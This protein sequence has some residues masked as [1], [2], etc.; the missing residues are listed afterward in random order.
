MVSPISAE[1]DKVSSLSHVSTVPL[2]RGSAVIKP[3]PRSIS[4]GLV[5]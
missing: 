4:P 3:G 2:V 5:M 1:T